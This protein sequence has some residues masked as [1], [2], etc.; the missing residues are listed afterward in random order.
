MYPNQELQFN[1]KPKLAHKRLLAFSYWLHAIA[2][3]EDELMLIS[4]PE[5][6][7]GQAKS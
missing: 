3:E 7:G 5:G 2:I 6:A 1:L 4:E